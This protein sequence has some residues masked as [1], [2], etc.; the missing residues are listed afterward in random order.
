[1]LAE[2][3]RGGGAKPADDE[4]LR[5]DDDGSFV[6]IRTVG[7]ERVGRFAGTLSKRA[8]AA[9][10][11]LVDGAEDATVAAE[12]LPPHVIET[13]TT[14]GAHLSVAAQSNPGPA[15]AKIIRRLRALSEELTAQPVAALELQVGAGGRSVGLRSVGSEPVDVDFG[16][17]ELA[18][19][20]FGEDEALIASETIPLPPELGRRQELAP[21]WSHELP[22]PE[23]LTFNP[24]RTLDVKLDFDLA[25]QGRPV[26]RARL[27]AIAGKGWGR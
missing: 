4:Q 25:D 8:A 27:S 11:K 15:A 9:L 20:L 22:L 10:A 21:G 5:I 7:G 2:Y 14:A 16:A 18:V 1:M 19:T 23:K 17:A 3:R 12:G 24:R 26:R 13:V 6:L